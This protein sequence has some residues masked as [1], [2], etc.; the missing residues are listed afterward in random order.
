MPSG[1][2]GRRE[3]A[4]ETEG[5]GEAG[6]RATGQSGQ[7]RGEDDHSQMLPRGAE[8]EAERTSLD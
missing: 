3:T 1:Y 2:G 4:K 7:E 5:G 8:E 6:R